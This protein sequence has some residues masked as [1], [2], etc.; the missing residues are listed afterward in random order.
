MDIGAGAGA[1]AFLHEHVSELG[2]RASVSL[3]RAQ[4]R[5]Q[6][7]ARQHQLDARGA[8]EFRLRAFR[9]RHQEDPAGHQHRRQRLGDVRQLPRTA[10]HGG[11]RTAARDDD[12]DSRAVG[13]SREHGPGTPRVLRISFLPDGAV[14]RPGLHRVHGRQ[15]ASA[16]ASTAT[17]CVRRVITSPRTTWSSWRRRPACCRWSRS[18]FC[19]KAGCSRAACFSWTP[20]RAASSPTRN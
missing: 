12:D 6:H 18:A 16:R 14:G 3:H 7:A 15:G 2:P 4:R 17:A 5:N 9:R 1:F 19:K 13:K 10:R 8:V 11:P 20:S